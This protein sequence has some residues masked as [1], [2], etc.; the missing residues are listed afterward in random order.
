ML[1]V[2]LARA[3]LAGVTQDRDA[4]ADIADSPFAIVRA[5]V[6]AEL[7][8]LDGTRD[9]AAGAWQKV[10]DLDGFGRA[11]IAVLVHLARA[12]AELGDAAGSARSCAAAIAP[13]LFHWSWSAAL[14]ACSELSA[15]R[16]RP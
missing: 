12:R 5:A 7:A 4:L 14:G 1:E 13:S 15:S 11:R 8:E 10:L 6:Q 9:V 2:G 16:S 3:L